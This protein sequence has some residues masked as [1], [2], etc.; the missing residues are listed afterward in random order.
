MVG[1]KVAGADDVAFLREQVGDDLL[2]CLGPSAPVRAMEQGRPFHLDDLEPD[3]RAALDT[4]QGAVDATVRDPDRFLRQMPNSTSATPA[5]GP[6]PPPAPTCPPR[7]TRAFA[8]PPPAGAVVVPTARVPA[9]ATTRT[10]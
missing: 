7:S 6:T 2:V 3:V 5:P 10:H 8:Y 4:V 1:N 9:Q